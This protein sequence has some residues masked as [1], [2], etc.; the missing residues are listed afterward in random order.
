MSNSVE[1]RVSRPDPSPVAWRRAPNWGPAGWAMACQAVEVL[2]HVAAGIIVARALGAEALGDLSYVMAVASALSVLLL[3]GTSDVAVSLYARGAARAQAIFTATT[4]VWVRGAGV[5][6]VL[7]T[8][9][10]VA[11]DLDPS[12]S[13]LVGLAVASLIVNGAASLLF[14]PILAFESA[15]HDFPSVVATRLLL[16]VGL[17]L[18]AHHGG[19]QHVLC[20][21]VVAAIALT[22]L[23]AIHV[24]RRLFRL[25]LVRDPEVERML[26][27]R[28]RKVGVGTVF[29]SITA[30]ADMLLLGGLVGPA[31]TGLYA[32]S[33]RFVNGLDAVTVAVATG[34]YPRLVRNLT[35]PSGM[36][37][38]AAFVGVGFCGSAAVL[39][40]VPFAESMVTLVYGPEFAAAGELLSVLLIA[41]AA[42]ISVAF[43]H[44]WWIANVREGLVPRAQGLSA[45]VNVTLNILWIPSFGALGAAW[46]TVAAQLSLL[47]FHAVALWLA[48]AERAPA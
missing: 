31:A 35:R 15:R 24:H 20:A 44:K 41:G 4:R 13:A 37:H 46:A 43:I 16:F 17:V 28:G 29:G 18:A 10:C 19:V 21:Y 48:R 23:R 38:F 14:L 30:R 39:C 2:T 36:T 33:Y 9:F 42:Q 7:A 26:W 47:A 34:L 8:L 5:C 27:H 40:L 1:P 45:A 6:G 25:R 32:A 3:F 11:I 12:R 22:C